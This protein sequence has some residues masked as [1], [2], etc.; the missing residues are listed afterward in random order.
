[1]AEFNKV[2]KWLSLF[3]FVA[4]SVVLVY[5]SCMPASVSSEHS[6]AVGGAVLDVTE[7][8]EGVVGGDNGA[9]TLSEQIKSNFGEFSRY[10]R[11]GIGHFGAFMVLAI[12]GIIGLSLTNYKTIPLALISL[13][14]GLFMATLTEA[15]QLVTP[16]RAGAVDDVLLDF[17]G[18]LCGATLVL[19]AIIIA[20]I[21][22]AVKTKKK[23]K[24]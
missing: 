21:T 2:I 7:K 14:Y 8:I 5:E 20:R 17:L 3:L 1:M 24:V 9:P 18:Y 22:T 6:G 23:N 4:L 12:L 15:I 13:I 11:K 19:I 10:I 16:G